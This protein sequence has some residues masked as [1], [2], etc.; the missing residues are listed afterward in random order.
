MIG[1]QTHWQHK[2][3]LIISQSQIAQDQ[4]IASDQF[5]RYHSIKTITLLKAQHVDRWN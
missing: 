4:E 3:L 2:S 1:E 5:I